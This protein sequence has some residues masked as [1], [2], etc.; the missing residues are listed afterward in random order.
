MTTTV[1]LHEA[2]THLSRLVDQAAQGR[3]FIIAKAGKPPVRVVPLQAVPAQRTLGFLAGQGVILDD[4]KAA[5]AAD[6]QAMFDGCRWPFQPASSSMWLLD[7]HLVL[8]WAFEPDRLSPRAGKLLRSRDKPIAFSLATIWEV[9]IE[10]SLGRPGF[11]V[12][13]SRLRLAL[14]AECFN[15][16][17]IQPA[18]VVRVATLPWRHRDPFD[19]LL[20]AQAAEEGLTLLLLTRC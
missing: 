20:V 18:H 16:L 10:T 4:V 14:L 15:E 1:N 6:I 8:R 9:A 5:F 3:E 12:D 17:P 11:S 2:K 19:R 7:T 13:P